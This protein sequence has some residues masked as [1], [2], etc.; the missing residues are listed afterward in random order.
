[1]K[2]IFF[3]LALLLLQT[4]CADNQPALTITQPVAVTKTPTRT[5]P[6]TRT[7]TLI[8]TITN[9]PTITPTSTPWPT[10]TPSGELKTHTWMADPILVYFNSWG[11][12]GGWFPQ[13]QNLV[14]YSDGQL[15]VYNVGF[16]GSGQYVTQLS[17]QEMCELL[18]TIDQIGFFDYDH[19][20]NNYQYFMGDG[21]STVNILVNAWQS[22]SFE[23][24]D[25]FGIAESAI[26]SR[27]EPSE[28]LNIA[29][30]TFRLLSNYS[31]DS[32]QLYLPE[33]IEIWLYPPAYGYEITELWPEGLPPLSELF[34]EA[35]LVEEVDEFGIESLRRLRLECEEGY[36]FIQAF[37]EL[38]HR[39]LYSDGE[40][41][42]V[43]NVIGLLPYP[44]PDMDPFSSGLY[45]NNTPPPTT[46][47][48]GPE[49]GLL[50]IPHP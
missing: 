9:T 15:F 43:V 12:D 17:R 37:N 10:I 27:V 38:P 2:R 8:P 46:L 36:L 41:T 23:V 25:L 13:P 20:T 22:K 24:P 1:M 3:A 34:E 5:S 28:S 14:L 42:L 50:A 31:S 18:N 6:P 29:M 35:Q 40:I 21:G 47:T 30:N 39:E 19:A 44:Y 48:C 45:L 4:A 11:G 26:Q 7:P 32:L 16:R 49:D 33:N